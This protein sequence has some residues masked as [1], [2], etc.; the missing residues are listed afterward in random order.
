M[1]PGIK[2]MTR[3]DAF[4]KIETLDKTKQNSKAQ[5]SKQ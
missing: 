4:Q 1:N 5:K 2:L 3:R